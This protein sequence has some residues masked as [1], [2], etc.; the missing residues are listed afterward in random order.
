MGPQGQRGVTGLTGDTGPQGVP[1]PTAVSSDAGNLATIGVDNL[2]LVP[3]T[4]R[5]LGVTDGSDA[6]PGEIGEYLN[7]YNIDG[8]TPTANVPITIC[9]I[10]LPVGCWE[11]WGACDFTISGIV[12]E[13][14]PGT[15]AG[16]VAPSQLAASISTTLDTLPTQDDLIVGTGVMNLI[17]SPLAAGQRQVLITGQCRSNST[18]PMTLYL[19][20]AVGSAN[21]NVKGYISARR[22]R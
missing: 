13:D 22:V 8:V 5:F 9:N 19:V 18:N 4:S 10:S 11:I 15:Q 14:L 20:A 17:Y 6:Q 21:A 3:N 7:V 2:L 16:A 12:L 1:G